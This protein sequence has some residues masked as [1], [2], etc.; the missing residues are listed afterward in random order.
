MVTSGPGVN[1][2][3]RAARPEHTQAQRTDAS[4][5]ALINATVKVLAEEGYGAASLARISEVAGLS[6]GLA[7][8]HFGSKIALMEEVVHQIAADYA[9]M[10][11]S[12]TA[13]A[14]GYERVVELFEN[15][16]DGMTRRRRQL[17]SSRVMLVL[18]AES[19]SDVPEL[20]TAVQ[21]A[22]ASFRQRLADF[23][24][25]GVADGSI[26]SSVDAEGHA[27]ALHGLLR[28]VVLQHFV[29]QNAVEL[30]IVSG[31]VLDVLHRTLVANGSDGEPLQ[32]GREA[33]TDAPEHREAAA[34]R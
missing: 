4:R 32:S 28:G 29:D 20:R 27:M 30:R 33:P 5:R 23:L 14:S 18:A 9:D 21:Q 25:E 8:Y 2:E 1:G 10:L 13:A 22:Y 7:N 34:L 19:V 31:A 24:S 15:Y 12:S 11:S 26:R 3:R 17:A 6:R 16:L